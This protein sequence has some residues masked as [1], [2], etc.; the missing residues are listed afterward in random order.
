MKQRLAGIKLKKIIPKK[1]GIGRNKEDRNR[2]NFGR[3][4]KRDRSWKTCGV[5]D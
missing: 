4:Q 2:E 1:T 5:Y 3:K